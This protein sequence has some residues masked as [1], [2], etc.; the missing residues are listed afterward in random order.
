[1]LKTVLEFAFW[2]VTQNEH[3]S[4]DKINCFRIMIVKNIISRWSDKFKDAVFKN[5]E[6]GL[7]PYI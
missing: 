4:C 6:A 1:M 5:I 3:Q 2:Q 7:I